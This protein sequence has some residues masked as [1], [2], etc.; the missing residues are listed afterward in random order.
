[1][2]LASARVVT[3]D[4]PRL[5][6]FYQEV[7]TVAP[8]G[9]DDY[10]ELRTPGGTL[11]ISSQRSMDL[12]AAGATAPGVNRSAIIDFEVDDVDE[13][14][15]R[16]RRL[17]PECV[18]EPTTQPWGNRSMLFRDPDGNLIN[19]FAPR[20]PRHGSGGRERVGRAG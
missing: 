13:E 10:V 2:R 4:V 17:I 20:A 1:M 14:R 15:S 3:N 6:R 9:G 12:F 5:A 18:L 16:L 11:A 19:V 7:T 8:V